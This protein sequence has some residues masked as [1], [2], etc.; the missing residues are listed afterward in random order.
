VCERLDSRSFARSLSLLDNLMVRQRPGQSLSDYVHYMRQ[1]FDDYNE[2]CLMV[3]GSAVIHPHN[4]GLLMLRGISINGPHGQAKQCVI[5]AFD[6]DY[7]LSVDQMRLAS[8][9]WHTI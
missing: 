3:D 9:T 5:N 7:M 6:T 2:T 8:S 4:L 1:T